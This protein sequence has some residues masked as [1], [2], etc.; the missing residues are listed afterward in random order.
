MRQLSEMV[1]SV[2]QFFRDHWICVTV[3]AVWVILFITFA[4]LVS[5]FCRLRANE[6]LDGVE[7]HYKQFNYN[8]TI[9]SDTLSTSCSLCAQNRK[10]PVRLAPKPPPVR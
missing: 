6:T 4:I 1:A 2:G 8:P 7:C 10:T 3:I 5:L 9:A